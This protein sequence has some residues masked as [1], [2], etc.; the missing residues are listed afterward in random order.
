MAWEALRTQP[1]KKVVYLTA[2]QAAVVLAQLQET[3]AYRGWFLLAAAV[4]RNHVHL[5]VGVSGDPEP[6]TLLRD[7]KSYASRALNK[8]WEKPASGTWWTEGGSKRKRE[9]VPAA[10]QYVQ[11]QEYPLVVWTAEGVADQGERGASAP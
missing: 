5:L 3:A 6:D 2:D 4:M 10:V 9:D 8:R 11:E 1:T 7:F